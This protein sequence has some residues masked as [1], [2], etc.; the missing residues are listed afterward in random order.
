M[1][2]RS[3]DDVRPRVMN[4]R[5]NRE[6]SDIHGAIAFHDFA[7]CI[8]QDQVR[9]ANMVEMHAERVDPEMVGAF[10]IARGDMAGHAFVET[11]LGKQAES[12]S[13]TLL[14]MPALLLRR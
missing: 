4:A 9:G 7:F 14:A 10:G 12:G 11:K 5:M 8:H 3:G 2:V 6:G 1:G 13:E